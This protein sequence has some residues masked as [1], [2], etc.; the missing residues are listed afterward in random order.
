MSF[1]S[2]PPFTISGS[3]DAES[4]ARLRDY[5]QHI[6]QERGSLQEIFE[7]K[8]KYSHF[9]GLLIFISQS[10]FFIP[11]MDVDVLLE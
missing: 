1:P 8:G 7:R 2:P 4:I 10:L 11:F 9:F 3:E 5:Y 6:A